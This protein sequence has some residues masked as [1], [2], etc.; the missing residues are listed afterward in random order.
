MVVIVEVCD[1]EPREVPHVKCKVGWLDVADKLQVNVKQCPRGEREKVEMRKVPY[2]SAVGS[3]M[4]AMVCTRP[5]TTFVVGAVSQY[6]SYL[7]REHSGAVKWVLRYLRGTSG[8]CLRYGVRKPM[9]E[10]FTDPNMSEDVD[11]SRSTS[12]Y[13]ITYVGGV[14]SWQS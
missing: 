13:V 1:K 6:M 11:S 8:V 14:V 7:G 2:A 9:L 5:N 10:V 4:Y 3:L 12:G